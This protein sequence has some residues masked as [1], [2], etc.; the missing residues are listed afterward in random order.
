M[1][2]RARSII[3]IYDSFIPASLLA[4]WQK[5]DALIPLTEKNINKNYEAR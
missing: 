5:F 1:I 4:Y 3:C 2:T